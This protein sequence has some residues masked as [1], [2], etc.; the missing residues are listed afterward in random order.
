MN[1]C[2]LAMAKNDNDDDD[3]NGVRYATSTNASAPKMDDEDDV[4]KFDPLEFI[5]HFS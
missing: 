5:P 2:A 3:E 4:I 1:I